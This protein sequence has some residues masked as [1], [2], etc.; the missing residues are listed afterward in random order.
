ML[1]DR[2]VHGISADGHQ[3]VR[4]DRAGKWYLEGPTATRKQITLTEAAQLAAHGTPHLDKPG[5]RTFDA[6]VRALTAP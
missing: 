4:Y 5:G 3:I 2:Q 1:N 6:R